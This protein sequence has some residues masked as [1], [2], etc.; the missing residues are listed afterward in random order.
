MTHNSSHNLQVIP[1][2]TTYLLPSSRGLQMLE[3]SSTMGICLFQFILSF[4]SL[5]L[6][7]W[8]VLKEPYFVMNYYTLAR[9]FLQNF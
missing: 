3:I 4:L 1:K 6:G 5:F 9:I 7:E 2:D 8:E